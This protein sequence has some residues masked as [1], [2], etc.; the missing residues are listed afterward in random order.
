MSHLV[1]LMDV[2]R[3]SAANAAVSAAAF[4]SPKTVR[5]T[6]QEYATA[7]FKINI[8]LQYP[9]ICETDDLLAAMA[10]LGKLKQVCAG[11][12]CTVD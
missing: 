12:Q 4:D 8:A 1:L 9:S 10:I 3:N 6:Q 7:L 11:C 5:K 2:S